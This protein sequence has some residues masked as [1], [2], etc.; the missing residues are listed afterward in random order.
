MLKKTSLFLVL[1]VQH[2]PSGNKCLEMIQLKV[3]KNCIK[4]FFLM[5][6]RKLKYFSQNWCKTKG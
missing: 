1:Y 2:E 5:L 6:C 4:L 3:Y